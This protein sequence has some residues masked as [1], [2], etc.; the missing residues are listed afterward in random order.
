MSIYIA[1]KDYTDINSLDNDE[2]AALSKE[3][4][5]SM[6]RYPRVNYDIDTGHDAHG[7]YIMVSVG[8]RTIYSHHRPYPSYD[9]INE[10][11]P[12]YQVFAQYDFVDHAWHEYLLFTGDGN[13]SILN[14]ENGEVF[15]ERESSDTVIPQGFKVF[16]I[17]EYYPM[18]DM[19]YSAW[20][21]LFDNGYYLSIL[22]LSGVF[23]LETGSEYED[24]PYPIMYHLD[25]SRIRDGILTRSDRYHGFKVS[26]LA[27]A[28]FDDGAILATKISSLNVADGADGL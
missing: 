11:A 4:L 16:P 13:A 26:S 25:M 24:D 18:R 5:H 1:D 3:L 7:Y 28:R 19:D 8:T 15:D 6:E 14:L 21:A 23:A 27:S 20:E 2:S 10:P 9:D 22:E 12:S 17:V